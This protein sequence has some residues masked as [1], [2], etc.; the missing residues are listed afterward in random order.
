MATPVETIDVVLDLD[1]ICGSVGETSKFVFELSLNPISLGGRKLTQ[2]WMS[3]RELYGNRGR[4]KSF[5]NRD[6]VIRCFAE[7]C[8]RD[9]SLAEDSEVLQSYILAHL[10]GDRSN[11]ARRVFLDSSL[12]HGI[13][14]DGQHPDSWYPQLEAAI[15]R[16]RDQTIDPVSFHC[17]TVCL[18][19]Q[20][21]Y[22]RE[23]LELYDY[24]ERQLFPWRD[25]RKL[26]SADSA[27]QHAETVWKEELRKIGRRSGKEA[28]KQVL[29][30]FA[31]ECRTAFH[32]AYSSVWYHLCD[33]LR[34]NGLV[35][36]FGFNFH[37]LWHLDQRFGAG[38]GR[39]HYLFHGSPFALHPASGYLLATP[40]GAALTRAWLERPADLRAQGRFLHAAFVALCDYASRHSDA[41][42]N[43]RKAVR[44]SA[45]RRP[46]RSS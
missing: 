27:L 42:V 7:F 24:L 2:H 35:D 36:D 45:V 44:M 17:K 14:D 39:Y 11:G 29:D 26:P 25:N 13:F 16:S 9:G 32:R 15:D 4:T 38:D 8:R 6:A 21:P 41:N 1:K 5:C 10:T 31:R 46:S 34:E 33:V 18:L 19:G 37:C 28:E 12:K 30:M 20:E 3:K 40:T 23:I 22:E 43:R